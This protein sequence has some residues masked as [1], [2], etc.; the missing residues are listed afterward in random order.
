M[1]APIRT[2]ACQLRELLGWVEEGRFAIPKLQ[3]EF[4]WDGPKAAKLFDSILAQ[5]PIGVAMVW[6]TPRN[7]R[8]Y[9]RQKYHVLPQFNPRNKRVWF[10]IDGQQRIS[11]L[12]RVNEGS[13]VRN[14]RGK[15]VYFER[16]VLALNPEPGEQ[17]VLYRKPRPGVYEPLCQ[18]LHPHWRAKLS[19]LG[20]RRLK[21]VRE[22]RERILNYPMHLMFVQGG[23]D[24]IRQAF[25]RIN[26]QGMKIGTADAI[27]TQAEDLD[28]RDIQHEVRGHIDASFGQVPEMPIFYAMAALQGAKEARG[29]AL[30]A[31][32]ARLNRDAK[33]DPR[34][35]KRLA[36]DWHELGPAF[37]K[38][39]DYLRQHFC[40]VSRD[41]LYSDYMLAILALFFC[42]NRRGP[43]SKQ[44]EAIRRW[45]WAT[46]VGSR[47]SGASFLKCIPADVEFFRRLAA[48]PSSRFSAEPE[49]EPIDVRRT[50]YASRSGIA[51]AFYCMLM[52]RRPVSILDPG[53]NPIPIDRYATRAN[54]KDRHHIF[55]RAQL[56]A[57]GVPA[58]RYNS[59][60]NICLLT[61][62]ENQRISSKR[63]R[64]YLKEARDE[65]GYF[66]R[67]ME[68]HLIP[69]GP[70]S[71]VWHRNI[72]A[73]FAA[74][75]KERQEW[76]C[77]ELEAQ[78]GMRLFRRST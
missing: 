7:Q 26:T 46:A 10:L 35:R 43:D 32:V 33:S 56:A 64:L 76:I 23:V 12:H 66:A 68:R 48:K 57:N 52:Q 8:L 55:P 22:A 27:F 53:L 41:Y 70:D 14:A 72:V 31:R 4:V 20:P 51:S 58:A 49:V 13:A 45:F 44:K 60:C 67:K 63:P 24:L 62:E 29:N 25:L 28:L 61:A 73:G 39:V 30:S 34:L 54:R 59:I 19:H 1:K 74:V 16:V 77:R 50:Q 78:A 21:R 65:T 2:Q 75:V 38:A 71:G 47:Y 42:W 9:L 36:R 15:T 17:T 3:R 6:E 5:M 37:G 18:V 69:A 11:V 40:V